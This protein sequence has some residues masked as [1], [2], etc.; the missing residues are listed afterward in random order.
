M[1]AADCPTAYKD[2]IIN[3]LNKKVFNYSKH[4]EKIVNHI[5]LKPEYSVKYIDTL[6]PGVK[7]KVIKPIKK[8]KSPKAKEKYQ[9]IFRGAALGN[10]GKTIQMLREICRIAKWEAKAM[11]D[12]PSV[13]ILKDGSIKD[14]R[15]AK[16]ALDT[17]FAKVEIISNKDRLY[18]ITNKHG[19]EVNVESLFYLMERFGYTEEKSSKILSSDAMTITREISHDEALEIHEQLATLGCETQII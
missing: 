9:L 5:V 10:K 17:V 16:K 2:I 4:N 15:K 11:V 14:L 3:S 6:R 7:G 1:I 12:K 18:T 13:V 8:A 19:G